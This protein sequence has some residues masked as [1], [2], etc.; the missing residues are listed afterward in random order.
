MNRV[1]I[2][3]IC[4]RPSVY[5]HTYIDSPHPV[6]L[7]LHC[8]LFAPLSLSEFSR[9]ISHDRYHEMKLTLPKFFSGRHL[10]PEDEIYK[11]LRNG[12]SPEHDEKYPHLH[13]HR[14]RK[15]TALPQWLAVF[16]LGTIF[17]MAMIWIF[18]VPHSPQ[19]PQDAIFGKSTPPFPPLSTPNIT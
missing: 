7:S 10:P 14:T 17:G 5:S 13:K 6:L 18:I 8:S 19:D 15:R 4:I 1:A 9:H 2:G 16:A 12:T 11:P 3:C